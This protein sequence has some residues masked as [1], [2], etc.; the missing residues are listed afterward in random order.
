MKV[1]H[2]NRRDPPSGKDDCRWETDSYSSKVS[3]CSKFNDR[4]ELN[5]LA[6]FRLSLAGLCSSS[7]KLSNSRSTRSSDEHRDEL[8][9]QRYSSMLEIVRRSILDCVPQVSEEMISRAIINAFADANIDKRVRVYP[10][11]ENL[12]RDQG[13]DEV[14]AICSAYNFSKRR[15]GSNMGRDPSDMQSF[16]QSILNDTFLK[17]QREEISSVDCALRIISAVS[18][19]LRLKVN[20]SMD[21][22]GDTIILQGLPKYTTRSD[23]NRELSQFGRIK[24]VAIASQNFNFGY[25]RYLDESS[26][27]NA[28]ANLYQIQIGGAKPI[29]KVLKLPIIKEYH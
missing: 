6:D 25:C 3:A 2:Q 8:H 16:L 18:C 11:I 29:I 19:V 21:L 24:S 7:R 27:K 26:T 12:Q 15:N 17:I 1:K 23:L 4:D 22:L 20:Q 9:S 13:Q 28:L 5:V 10:E 14:D